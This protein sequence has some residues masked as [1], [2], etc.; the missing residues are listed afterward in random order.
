MDLLLKQWRSQKQNESEEQSSA[1]KISN[2]FSDQTQ[3]QTASSAAALPLFVLKPTS[4]SSIACFSPNTSSSRFLKMGNFYSLAQWQELELQALIYR[5]MLAGASVPPELLLPIKKSL[6]HQSPLNFLHH[7]QQQNFPH[8]QPWY[9][10][11]GAMDL[12]PG[13]CKRT[14]GKKWRCSRDVVD[15]HKYCDRHIHRGRNRS[16]KPV[17]LVKTATTTAASSFVLGEDLD[18]EPNTLFFSSDSSRSSTQNLHLT[19]HQSCSSEMKQENNNNNNKRPYEAHI[20]FSNG[21]SDDGHTLRHFFDDWP[22]SSDSTSSPMSSNCHIS[23]SIPGNTSSDVSLKLSTSNEVEEANN[24]ERELQQSMNY[25]NSGGNHHNMG[26]PL[27][28][29]LRSAS[30]TSSVLHQMGISTQIFR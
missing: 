6:F 20:R 27:A 2:F 10:G 14:D 24:N 1:T 30:S 23:I 7:P 9:W 21:R 26:G 16:R 13:R 25:W 12:E 17:E 3:S 19:S 11:R 5:Y 8:H 18:H 15:G 28:E 29:A 22:R 4:S